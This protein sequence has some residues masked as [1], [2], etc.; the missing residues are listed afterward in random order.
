MSYRYEGPDM[1]GFVGS[2]AEV[3]VGLS[4]VTRLVAG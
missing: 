3:F 4:Q 1:L 2:K